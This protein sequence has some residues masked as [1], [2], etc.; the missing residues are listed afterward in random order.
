M[1]DIK[2]FLK[3]KKKK[4]YNVVMKDAK[5]SQQMKNKSW[6]SIEKNVKRE[7]TPYNYKELF[8]VENLV[9]CLRV[10]PV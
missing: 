6:L 8:I 10:G 4:S 5:I 9:F 3:K 7:K 2:V 1:K